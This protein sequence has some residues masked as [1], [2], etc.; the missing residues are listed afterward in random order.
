MG[1]I[2]TITDGIFEILQNKTTAHRTMIE[3]IEYVS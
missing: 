2:I 3:M 1:S